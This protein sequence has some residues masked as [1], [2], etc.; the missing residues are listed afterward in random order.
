MPA[1]A[2]RARAAS[3]IPWISVRGGE[4]ATW[5]DVDDPTIGHV[6]IFEVSATWHLDRLAFDATELRTT[7]LDSARRRERRRVALR[8]VWAFYRWL[9][10]SA[11]AERTGRPTARADE[12]SA[13]LDALTDGWFG[14]RITD[15]PATG[16]PER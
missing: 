2:R 13:E 6:T 16:Q 5:R 4:D 14:R 3:L 10:A 12:A 9:S 7:A 8:V 1:L 15:R 11:V